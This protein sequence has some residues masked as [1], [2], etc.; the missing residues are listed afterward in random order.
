MNRHFIILC[1]LIFFAGTACAQKIDTAKTTRK[2]SLNRVKDSITSKPV[3]PKV[4]SKKNTKKYNPDSTHSPG[5][6]FKRSAIIPGWGQLYNHRWWKVPIVYTGLGL[7]GSAIIYNQKYYKQYLRIYN[8]K[9]NAQQPDDGD[10]AEIKKLY[11][12]LAGVSTTA[13]EGAVNGYQRNMQLSIL[14]VIGAW[15]IQMIDAYI[16]AK[17]IHSYTMDRD[18]SFKVSPGI[19]ASPLY[20]GGTMAVM[21]VIKLTFT[22]K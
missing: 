5:L 15:G 4:L 20:A 2:D 6:A 14:G 12:D 22:L 16:D 17:F 13:I 10:S 1:L 18:L 19:N 7:L 8:L 9:R 3:I 11:S 21:P